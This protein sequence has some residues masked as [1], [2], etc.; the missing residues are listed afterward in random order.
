MRARGVKVSYYT[1]GEGKKT[2]G[3]VAELDSKWRYMIRL[4][5]AVLAPIK[6]EAA[7]D[8]KT[9]IYSEALLRT[10]S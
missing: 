9:P 6:E 7:Y 4:K 8:G 1:S 5:W 2:V 10:L 3:T